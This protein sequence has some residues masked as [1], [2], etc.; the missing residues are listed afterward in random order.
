M[1]CVEDVNFSA[2][3]VAAIGFGL[4]RIEREVVLT[5]D[6]QQPRLFLVPI[7]GTRMVLKGSLRALGAT[8]SRETLAYDS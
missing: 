1:P 2:R 7:L 5:P 4:G 8:L 6:H 3:H